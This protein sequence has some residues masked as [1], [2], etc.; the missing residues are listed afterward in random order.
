[1]QISACTEERVTVG[2]SG[3]TSN[4]T[5]VHVQSL[6]ILSFATISSLTCQSKFPVISHPSGI[7]VSL[8]WKAQAL[9]LQTRSGT[10]YLGFYTRI[11]STGHVIRREPQ[12]ALNDTIVQGSVS[13]AGQTWVQDADTL[14][15][16][17]S[18]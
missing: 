11:D 18:V 10:W 14:I 5:T 1:M 2:C 17:P 13:G 15:L 4:A 7:S 8:M 9:V 3:K 6:A 16:A 12:R